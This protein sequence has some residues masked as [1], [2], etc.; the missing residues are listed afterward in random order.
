[1]GKKK[2]V[3]L[4]TLI[5]IVLLVLCAIV[6]FPSVKLDKNGIKK[7]NPA[8][9]QYDLGSEFSG[10]HYAYYYPEGIIPETEYQSDLAALEGEEK[11]EYED[12][13][14]QFGS[15]YLSTNP[16]DCILD[17]SG[18]VTEGFKTAF[19]KT[20]ALLTE[21]FEERA[22]KTGST[23][24]L[25]VVENYALRIDISASETTKELDSS[26]Y[27]YQ[28]FEL[29]ANTGELGIYKTTEN[30]TELVDEL[31]DEDANVRDLIKSISV[32][33]QY[34][35]AYVKITF[36]SKGKEV[37]KNFRGSD[38]ITSLSFRVGETD[39]LK[40]EQSNVDN[41][42][43]TKDEVL[44]GV[45]YDSENLYAD[46]LCILLNSAM[47]KGGVYINENE[48]AP[49]RLKA[50]TQSDIRTYEAVDGELWGLDTLLWVYFAVLAILLFVVVFGVVRMGGF[51]AMNLYT[52]LT[53]FAIVA[54]CYAFISKGVFVV[55]LG[56][57]F[58]FL[59]GLV[60]T[61]VLNGYIYRAIKSEAAQGKTIV[62][63]VKGGYKKTLWTVVD[64]YAVLLL[65][66]VAF[67]LGV[68]SLNTLAIQ[69]IICVVTGAFCNLLWGRALNCMLLSAHKDK[70]K[71]FRLVREDDDDE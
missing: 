5:T 22:A 45:R 6:A 59:V 43:N 46:T 21:R 62:S 37:I 19:N 8:V 56:S 28:A 65:G 57:I 63:S 30:A 61:S 27:A 17:E 40:I 69:A 64:I 31:K 60:L 3:V 24:R 4:M 67:L 16:D 15:L 49:L 23:Y 52:A 70:Y 13:Y 32:K 25:S 50:P 11:G 9:L 10:G 42:I 51:G 2:S 58:V 20:V 38:T 14:K 44:Y 55:S 34:D 1:M 26:S 47:E 18:N 33:D 53:Y 71:Y 39:L 12:A 7:W 68:G 35:I 36:T 54:F 29:F 48:E 41:V 66:A